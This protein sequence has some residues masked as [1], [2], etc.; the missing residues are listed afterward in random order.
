MARNRQDFTEILYLNLTGSNIAAFSYSENSYA[1]QFL[2]KPPRNVCDDSWQTF[3]NARRST[4]TNTTTL[5]AGSLSPLS[6]KY[7]GP[8]LM[9]NF[10]TFGP[11]SFIDT[12]PAAYAAMEAES[13][14]TGAVTMDSSDIWIANPPLSN[15]ILDKSEGPFYDLCIS[16]DILG[17]EEWSPAGSS[18]SARL[19]WFT[20]NADR[21]PS[22]FTAAAYLCNAQLL[23]D[24]Y[25]NLGKDLEIPSISLL[26]IVLV[27]ILIGIYLIPLLIL[28]LYTGNPVRWTGHLDSFVML[29]FRAPA[30][31]K[32]FPIWTMC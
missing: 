22:V 25:Q 32:V 9:T 12:F 2:Y 8:L 21:F 19:Q 5:T 11:D 24:V 7:K 1:T 27:S 30:G 4:T 14:A 10:A 6:T 13:K 23:S 3:K 28:G 16:F 31:V 17:D 26:G 15:L 29:R 20:N 18:I